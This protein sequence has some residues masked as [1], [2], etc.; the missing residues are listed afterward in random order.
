MMQHILKRLAF[1]SLVT[2][3]MSC[4][5]SDEE[6]ERFEVLDWDA[7]EERYLVQESSI[8]TLEDR[9]EVSGE[10]AYLR[11]GGKLEAGTSEPETREEYEDALRVRGDEDPRARWEVDD[12]VVVGWDY[13]SFLMY[14]LYHHLEKSAIYFESIGVERDVVGRMPVYYAPEMNL[15]FIPINVFT[16]NAAYA[17]TLDAFLV[18][19]QFLSRDLPLAANRGVI[20]HE[21]SHAVFNRVVHDDQRVPDY[22]FEE[23]EDPYVNRMN[24]LNEGVAD[25]FGALAVQEPNFIEPSFS[26]ETFDVDRDLTKEREYT[27]DLEETLEQSADAFN[28][29]KIGSVIA[30]TVWALRDAVDDDEALG[31][32]VIDALEDFAE[33][34]PEYTLADFFNP[35]YDHLPSHAQDEACDIFEERLTAISE[36]LTCVQ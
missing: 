1:F 22:L 21:Y 15:G 9:R 14:T 6:T 34:E 30:S 11:G 27:E 12:G 29:Y 13:Q 33:V 28:P 3:L 23:W 2:L 36:E 7:D 31:S 4:G 25:I 10:I 8:E 17:F 32:A 24:A 5:G 18:P 35:F 20:V 16:D 26:E 19:P